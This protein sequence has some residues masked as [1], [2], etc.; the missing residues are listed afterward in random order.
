MRTTKAFRKSLDSSGF[1]LVELM[2]VV[3]IIGILAA[4][5]IPNYQKYQARA[6]QSEAKIALAALY[7]A[8]KSYAVENSSFSTCLFDVG[9]QPQGAQV[10]YATGF[11]A[12]ALSGSC[13]P[14]GA[15]TCQATWPG[16]VATACTAPTSGFGA[17]SA[18][19]FAYEATAKI[20]AGG[21]L[22]V[23]GDLTATLMTQ[24]NFTAESS[25]SISQSNTVKDHWTVNDQKVITNNLNGI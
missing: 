22:G 19:F 1:T 21:A 14:A 23:H 15:T 12:G 25:G 8:Q 13:G 17:G 18:T 9:Y 3:A 20:N 6:R 10:Y 4:V 16:G 24:S 2:I 5:A 7:T 11:S